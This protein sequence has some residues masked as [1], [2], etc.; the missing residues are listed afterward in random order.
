MMQQAHKLLQKFY[1]YSS[2]RRGQEQV[3][4]SILEG[5]DTLA[6]MPTGGGKSIC[7]Q[8]PAL[9]MEG[10]TL[11][12]SPLISLM[13]DQVDALNQMGIPSAYINSSLSFAEITYHMDQATAGK[14]KLLYVAPERLE[15]SRF[16]ALLQSIRIPLVAID[17][18]HC[19]SQWGHDFRPSYLSIAP[20]VQ[21]FSPRPIVAAFTATATEEVQQDIIRQLSLTGSQVFATGFGRENLSF[22][23]KRGG[24]KDSFVLR[25]LKEKRE[26]AGIIYAATRKDVDRLF[27]L[28][29]E[30]GFQVGRYHAGLDEEEREK[31]Q[32]R[33][34][35]DDIRVIVATN[36]FGM[37]IDK[38][39]VRFV[40]HYNMPKNA[41]AYYQEAGRAG[42]DGDPAECTLLFSPQDPHIQKYIIEQSILTPERKAG[43]LQK[44]R[45]MINYCHTQ[46]CLQN[47][48]LEYFG[49]H[50]QVGCGKCSNCESTGERVDFTEVAQKILSCVKRMDQRFGISLVAQ[51]LKGSKAR[52]LRELGFHH[53]STYGLLKNETQQ[54]I[55]DQIH[56]LVAEGYLQVSGGEYPTVQLTPKSVHVLKGKR[57]V[58]RKVDQQQ[59]QSTVSEKEKLVTD[60]ELFEVLRQWR[61]ETAQRE[62]VAPFIIFHDRTLREI[63]ERSPATLSDLRKV[64]GVGEKKIAKYGE[65][66]LSLLKE[67]KASLTKGSDKEAERTEKVE[68]S[69]HL[70][71]RLFQAGKSVGQIADE[72]SLSQSTIESHLLRCWEEGRVVDW[73]RL[74]L[75]GYEELILRKAKEIGAE[76]L[77]PLKEALP[78]EVDYLSIRAVLR[79]H[80]LHRPPTKTT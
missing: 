43:E 42:R 58:F 33:F 64:P 36:A 74:I 51:V 1:G 30:S 73:D 39:N 8:L 46:N 9:L 20:L 62:Q 24:N 52:R 54:E 21:S 31:T 13:K 60:R 55:V 22:Y 44:L 65:D 6:L 63:C 17:E 77:K 26:E 11:V 49:E 40:L 29:Q 66:V 3:I 7:Y 34:L 53:L 2:F 80:N 32:E 56:F 5:R 37:G 45:V 70:S 38:S 19:I 75:P 12:V 57:Q 18:A 25:Y 71:L 14:Y 76:R 4:G 15:S 78:D 10:V 69:H 50:P 59:K 16:Q 72:R 68:A 48:L 47:Y 79:K 67:Y 41:E 28:L 27:R 23:V 35:Y 61:K